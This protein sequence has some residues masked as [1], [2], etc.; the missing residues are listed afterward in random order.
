MDDLYANAW[1][2]PSQPPLSDFKP[3]TSSSKSWLSPKLPDAHEEADLAAPS[4]STGAGIGWNE[5]SDSAGFSWGQADT[6]LA[7]GASS[8][9]NIPIGKSV[10]TGEEDVLAAD[11]PVVQEEPPPSPASPSPESSPEVREPSPP[12]PV[13]EVLATAV[14]FADAEVLSPPAEHDAFGTFE[15]ALAPTEDATLALE[16]NVLNTDAWGSAWASELEQKEAE[17]AERV[18]EWEAARQRKAQQDRKIPPSVMAAM[19]RDCEQFCEEAWPEPKSPDA[20]DKDEWKNNWRR[21]IEGVEGLEALVNTFLPPL[22]LQPPVQF[23]KAATAKRMAMSVRLT[24]NMAMSKRSPMAHYLTAKGSTAWEV[25]VKE[26]KEVIGDDMPA[27]WRILEKESAGDAAAGT[28]KEKKPAGRLFSFWGRRESSTTSAHTRSSSQS[29]A[30]DETSSRSPVV[31]NI[32]HS[33]RPSQDSV[34]SL[35]SGSAD[36]SAPPTRHSSSSPAPSANASTSSL[37]AAPARSTSYADAPEPQVDTNN[38]Q[39]PSAVSRFWDR[40]SRRRST[41]GSGSPRNSLAL[42][43]DDLEFLAEIPSAN[44]GEDDEEATLKAFESVFNSKPQPS[45]LPAPLPA[46]LPPPP[47]VNTAVRSV[48]A[49]ETCHASRRLVQKRHSVCQPIALVSGEESH[50]RTTFLPA[51]SS[52]LALSHSSPRRTKCPQRAGA[53]PDA[54]CHAGGRAKGLIVEAPSAVAPATMGAHAYINVILSCRWDRKPAR[55]SHIGVAAGGIVSGRVS[56]A[57]E[58][59]CGVQACLQGADGCISHTAAADELAI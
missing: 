39:A 58:Q 18:D 36:K 12:P 13:Q 22:S 40:F 53:I 6:D 56:G 19:I 59:E 57:G 11:P 24:K 10:A 14:P 2:E 43:S 26:R 9:D 7:W 25:A 23:G 37:P 38:A 31:E 55:H 52:L 49:V 16:E 3:S 28:I 32:G 33:R 30:R 8:Y 20:K 47:S 27:G 1:D 51:L 5:P 4:W 46:P 42:S 21:G 41:M 34:R 44:D 50:P 15:S 48:A 54:A 29:D 35:A 17:E 45:V